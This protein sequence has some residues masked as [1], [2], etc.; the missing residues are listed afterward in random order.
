[1]KRGKSALVAVACIAVLMVTF[2]LPTAAARG[3]GDSTTANW[4]GHII[5]VWPNGHDDTADLQAAFNSCTSHGW[6]CTVQLVKGTYYTAQISVFGF[7]GSFVGAGQGQTVI[8]ALPNLP[9]PAALYNSPT[10]PFWAGTP[11]TSNPWPD[12]FTFVGG[13]FS[14][15]GMTMIEPYANPI[16]SPGWYWNPDLPAGTTATDLYALV[17][18]TGEVANAAFDHV[19]MIGAGGDLSIPLGTP[20]TFNLADEIVYAGMFLPA[21]WTSAWGDQIPLSGA[22]SLTQSVLNGSISAIWIENVLDASAMICFNSIGSSPAPGFMDISGT[23]LLFCSNR[24]TN[25]AYATAF[26]GSQSYYKSDLLPSTVTVVDNYMAV[27][28]E[29]SGIVFFDYGAEFYGVASTLSA[30]V[31]GNV[32]VSDMSCGCY[33]WQV[34]VVGLS[35]SLV[36]SVWSDNLIIGGGDGIA[37]NNNYAA[38]NTGPVTISGNTV[39][40]ANLGMSVDAANEVHITG[41]V[42]KNS[43]SYGIWVFGGSSDTVVAHNLVTGSALYDLYWDQTGTGNQWIGNICQTSS[44]SG[45]C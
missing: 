14:V 27:N 29:G 2:G 18:V 13:T 36:S 34:S 19:T 23:Q 43:G 26:G 30:V 11:G 39:L 32:I 6:T 45:L 5:V 10:V 3:A 17:L 24:V 20:S 28:W 16:A 8:Q 44:P 31:A 9:A 35:Y 7:Q 25:V 12:L 21:G 42:I 41:N 1:M 4:G 40:G 15:S 38:S 37:V 33:T 22:F